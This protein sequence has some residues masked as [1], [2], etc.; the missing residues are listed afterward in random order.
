M[1]TR[2]ARRFVPAPLRRRINHLLGAGIRYSG[3]HADWAD[4]QRHCAGYDREHILQRVRATS[5]RV[6][7]GEFAYEQDSVG[8]VEPSPPRNLLRA[9]EAAAAANPMASG[10]LN[11]LD[12]G[13]SLGSLFQRVRPWLGKVEV[14][15]WLVCEQPHFVAC[16]RAEFLDHPLDFSTNPADALRRG[17]VDLL[18]LSSVLPYLPDPIGTLRDLA[19]L[20]PR[21]ILIDRTPLA[22]DGNDHLFVQ[23]TPRSIYRASYPCWWL[24]RR[25]L[26]HALEGRHACDAVLECTEGAVASGIFEADYCAMLWRSTGT[27]GKRYE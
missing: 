9:L 26:D 25:S 19:A 5:L 2:L 17:P 7:A 12:F 8:F 4:A 11:V 14:A 13:G 27:A 3:P 18:V 20:E 10:G 24:S 21:Y 16:G 22:R 15:Q 1:I 6:R 23:H